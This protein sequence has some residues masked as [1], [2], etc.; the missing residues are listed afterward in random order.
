MLKPP[1]LTGERVYL[2]PLSMND[3]VG[4]AAWFDSPFP[5][6]ASRAE[7]ALKEEHKNPWY[8]GQTTRL[9]VVRMENDEVV[10][11]ATVEPH[12]GA[13]RAWLWFKLAPWLADGDE[14]RADALRV[15]IRWL[16][17]D[18][19]LMA[20]IVPIAADEAATLAAAEEL[21]MVQGVRLRQSRARPGGRV[22]M[23]YYQA[24]NPRWEV[25]N[26]DA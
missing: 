14:L 16:R 17:D 9:A 13:R 20:T 5:V 1:Y 18:F 11:G 25:R 22:D 19:E 12:D 2:R 7:E 4:A 3:K 24:L 23:L 15:A 8:L 6:G 10:G 21:G 26:S